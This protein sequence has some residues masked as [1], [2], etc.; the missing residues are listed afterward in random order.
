MKAIGLLDSGT[1]EI[2]DEYARELKAGKIFKQM[3]DA[4]IE[5]NN[6]NKE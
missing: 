5:R 4:T 1:V 3:V 2:W 6:N